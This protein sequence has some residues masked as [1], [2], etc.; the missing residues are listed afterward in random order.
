VTLAPEPNYPS[1]PDQE[2]K[3]SAKSLPEDYDVC[4]DRDCSHPKE[5]PLL[6]SGATVYVV[7]GVKDFHWLA[8]DVAHVMSSNVVCFHFHQFYNL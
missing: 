4:K 6:E 3:V 5:R 8:S 1:K 2:T 7:F